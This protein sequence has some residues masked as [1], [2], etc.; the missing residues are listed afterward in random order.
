MQLLTT[1]FEDRTFRY[2]QVE[3]HGD[4]AIFAQRHKE[5]KVTRY[6]VVRVRVQPEHTWPNGTTSPER[7]VY[8]NSNAWDTWGWT[9]H[10]LPDAQKHAEALLKQHPQ[11]EE[12]PATCTK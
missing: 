5:G 4:V 8:P 10:K 12:D 11:A 9:F 3:R 6:E 2:T 7:E 1:A